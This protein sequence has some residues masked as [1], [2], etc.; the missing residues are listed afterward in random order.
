INQCL[1]FTP[2]TLPD[3][4]H[5]T[6]LEP[7]HVPP[8]LPPGNGVPVCQSVRSRTSSGCSTYRHLCLL[9]GSEAEVFSCGKT[10]GK[11]AHFRVR[12]C[13]WGNQRTRYPAHYPLAFACS[14]LL[15]PPSHRRLLRGA[16][17][18]Q[19][20]GR[21]TGLPRSARLPAGVRSCLYA[22]GA[23]SAPK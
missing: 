18:N 16:F 22:G 11:S 21:T 13:C 23:T 17:P 14:L 4:L 12:G 9:L 10:G 7:T 3:R 15:C 19:S 8:D 2:S 5:D 1:D 20:F 6:R